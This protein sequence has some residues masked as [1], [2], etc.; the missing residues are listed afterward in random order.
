MTHR[1]YIIAL[2]NH[3][4]TDFVPYEF[5]ANS[6]AYEKLT[7]Y[8]GSDEWTKKLL[9]PLAGSPAYFDS[10]NTFKRLDPNNPYLFS[11]AYG[12]HWRQ[13]PGTP[14]H[15][16]KSAMEGV[17]PKEYKWPTIDD[18]FGE[19][20][21]AEMQ[22][23]LDNIPTDRFTL[24]N[25]G[26]GHWE[27]M[28]RLLG[29]EEALMLTIDDP[30][31]FDELVEHLDI[32][33]NQFM[34]YFLD[35]PGDSFYICDDWCDQRTCMFGIETWRRHFK[36]RLARLY[37]KAHDAGKYVIQHVCGNVEPLIPDLIEIGL[38]MLESVQPEAM[39]VYKMKQLYGDKISFFGGLGVQNIVNFGT[40]DE[41]RDEIRRLRREI[42]AG[43]GFLLS[44]AKHLDGLQPVENLAAIYETFIEE[45]DKFN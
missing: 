22:G 17:D 23:W 43:G 18:F 4:D 35:K 34:D 11:D 10:W 15:L 14:P 24:I 26:A 28:W 39:D 37:K 36:P 21:R 7:A 30:E 1:D 27:L 6:L 19:K 9:W 32:L 25:L 12:A 16:E 20:Q 13:E 8:Y 44:P 40:P 3:K 38:D 42:G 45:N 33:I 41:I 29:V 2:L 5:R 31:L